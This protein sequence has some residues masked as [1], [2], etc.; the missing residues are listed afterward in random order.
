MDDD[1]DEKKQINYWNY[2]KMEEDE[3][4][5]NETSLHFLRNIILIIKIK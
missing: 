4:S 2:S 5:L 1:D 3:V